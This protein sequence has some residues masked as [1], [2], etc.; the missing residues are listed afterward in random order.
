MT[1]SGLRG[2][3]PLAARHSP[4]RPGQQAHRERVLAGS[5]SVKPRAVPSRDV[6]PGWPWGRSAPPER[7]AVP[8][9]LPDGLQLRSASASAR[10]WC[11]CPRSA[12]STTTLCRAG[13]GPP[14]GPPARR[15]NRGPAPGSAPLTTNARRVRSAPRSAPT[16]GGPQC[17][18]T[19]DRDPSGSGGAGA[20]VGP[21]R[22][23]GVGGQCVTAGYELPSCATGDGVADSFDE[24]YMTHPC[25]VRP[26]FS[27][28]GPN[29]GAG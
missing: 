3:A 7:V 13:P 25:L 16:G 12:Y 21:Y 29:L 24:P 1:G 19:R 14:A 28:G 5:A 10:W 26:G 15:R 8:D 4:R 18:G 11:R 27:L 22:G 2:Q 9:D 23:Q 6:T 20:D 17:A